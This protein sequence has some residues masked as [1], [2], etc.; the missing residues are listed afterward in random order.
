M[1]LVGGGWGGDWIVTW[2]QMNPAWCWSNC[3]FFFSPLCFSCLHIKVSFWTKGNILPLRGLMRVTWLWVW[4]KLH[5]FVDINAV[6]T[7]CA[8]HNS[9]HTPMA[10]H[11]ARCNAA[12][13][14]LAWFLIAIHALLKVNGWCWPLKRH[15]T[16]DLLTEHCSVGPPQKS[17]GESA[18]YKKH[19]LE[20]LF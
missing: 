2:H 4:I 14:S 6:T 19:W 8:Q 18:A 10:I 16:A 20:N 7:C 12:M 11:S 9:G 13:Q 5:P 3:T 17:A 1:E 15:R